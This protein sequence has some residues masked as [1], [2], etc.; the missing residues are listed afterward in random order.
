MMGIYTRAHEHDK[1]AALFKRL[2][3]KFEHCEMLIKTLADI[4]P[5][6]ATKFLKDKMILNRKDLD[7]D[8]EYFNIVLSSWANSERTDSIDQVLE[9]LRIIKVLAV[10][11]DLK[12][13]KLLL[14]AIANSK[15]I[16]AWRKARSEVERLES[17]FFN[18]ATKQ[19]DETPETDLYS[20]LIKIW[21]E[22]ELPQAS[23]HMER[24]MV[25][26]R[27]YTGVYGI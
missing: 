18:L 9:I 13:F 12:T 22:S 16:D 1:A 8:I 23:K 26:W 7:V 5:E 20:N 21:S 24:L 6:R 25:E 4:D 15:K 14:R 11:P 19:T 10:E 3:F 27:E 2:E 17:H